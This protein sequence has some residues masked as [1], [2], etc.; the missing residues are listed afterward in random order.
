MIR[1]QIQR[2][3]NHMSVTKSEQAVATRTSLAS[4]EPTASMVGYLKL[5]TFEQTEL[6]TKFIVV[7]K[8][9][10]LRAGERSASMARVLLAEDDDAVRSMLQAALERDGFEV[11]AVANVREALS[12]IAA[13]NFDVL[14]SD[15]HMPHA[16]DGFTVVSA[17]R[18]THPKAATLVLS[19]YPELDAPLAAIRLQADKVPVKPT[20]IPSPREIIP[21]P[22]ANPSPHSQPLPTPN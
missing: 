11:V 20:T 9:A 6:T 13:E 3:A 4:T 16:G 12:R 17:M 18:H 22:L 19:G 8:S 14:L 5:C 10:F 1:R 15:L 21:K 7:G 2:M